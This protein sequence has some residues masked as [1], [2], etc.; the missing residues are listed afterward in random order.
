MRMDQARRHCS[1]L[2]STHSERQTH[3]LR[4]G[5]SEGTQGQSSVSSYKLQ[6]TLAINLVG[7]GWNASECADV[8]MPCPS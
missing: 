8:H 1:V 7:S 5:V 4:V 3:D 2:F 6:L